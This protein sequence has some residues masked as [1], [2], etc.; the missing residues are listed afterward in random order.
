MTKLFNDQWQCPQCKVKHAKETLFK[1]WVR[2]HPELDSRDGFL[3]YDADFWV[4]RYKIHGS[5]SIQCLMMVE[6]KTHGATCDASQD[7]TLALVNQCL[8]NRRSNIH[9]DPE[10]RQA[11]GLPLK[12]WSKLQGRD[13]S[14]RVFGVHLLTFEGNG[15][16]DSSW[17]KW[18]NR[19]ISE[20]QLLGLLSFD[21]DP[22]YMRP[23][24]LRIHQRKKEHPTLF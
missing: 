15:P 13:V 6:V 19:P 11:A 16:Q 7:D 21:I 3:I 12:L 24:D 17:I 9:G 18:D 23:L 14:T 20:D 1:Q 10:R 8:R 22:D 5:R 2:S 4:H